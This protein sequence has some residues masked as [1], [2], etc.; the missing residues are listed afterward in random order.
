MARRM[1]A[2]AL[3][4][5][6]CS[7]AAPHP[8]ST[9]ADLG[10]WITADEPAPARSRALLAGSSPIARG[11]VTLSSHVVEGPRPRRAAR[12]DVNFEKA[13]MMNAF[14]LLANAGSFNLVM[15]D[16][17]AGHLSATL[18]GID[19]YDALVALAEANGVAVRYQAGVV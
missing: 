2:I 15:Q 19:P 3:V 14:Q 17:L 11:P 6:G 10:A 13:E 5:S 4:V 7:S 18:K 1:L 8:A 12:V 9:S 16:G